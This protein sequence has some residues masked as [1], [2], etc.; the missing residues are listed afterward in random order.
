MSVFLVIHENVYFLQFLFIY[1]SEQYIN[2]FA[3][4]FALHC[5]FLFMTLTQQEAFEGPVEIT[6]EHFLRRFKRLSTEF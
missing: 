4:L 1:S 6:N 5:Y 2:L 3:S